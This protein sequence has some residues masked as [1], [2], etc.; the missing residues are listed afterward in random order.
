MDSLVPG[1][2]RWTSVKPEL[3]LLQIKLQHVVETTNHPSLCLL[4]LYRGYYKSLK[5]NDA[6]S[7]LKYDVNNQRGANSKIRNII[8]VSITTHIE[9]VTV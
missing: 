6:S 3:L 5:L 7:K 9:D 1:G 2:F 4:F 8:N